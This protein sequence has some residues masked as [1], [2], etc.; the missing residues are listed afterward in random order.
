MQFYRP[1]YLR[2]VTAN[3][4]VRPVVVTNGRFSSE[5]KRQAIEA[6]VTLIERIELEERLNACACSLAELEAVEDQRL[7]RMAHM[8]AAVLDAISRAS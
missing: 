5:A 1:R 8:R 4:V 7:P 6:G 3:S 2:D